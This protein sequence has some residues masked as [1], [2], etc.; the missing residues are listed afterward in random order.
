MHFVQSFVSNVDYF[1]EYFSTS[2]YYML[3]GLIYVVYIGAAIGIAYFN[4]EYVKYLNIVIQTMIALVLIIRFNPFRKEIKCNKNDRV[5]ILA[6]SFFLLLN[7][8][9]VES[10]RAQFKKHILTQSFDLL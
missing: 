7:D 6:S 9:F 10:L 3:V 1:I 4:P 5:F 2:V 8:E